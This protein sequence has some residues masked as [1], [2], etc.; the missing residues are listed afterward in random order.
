MKAIAINDYTVSLND[1]DEITIT[2]KDTDITADIIGKNP[3]VD[4]LVTSII[5]AIDTCDNVIEQNKQLIAEGWKE[6]D[7]LRTEYDSLTNK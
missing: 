6:I 7:K 1:N 2:Y 4:I 3:D 5:K